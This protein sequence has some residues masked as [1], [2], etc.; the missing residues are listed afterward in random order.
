[1]GLIPVYVIFC[2]ADGP[3]EQTV[4]NIHRIKIVDAYVASLSDGNELSVYMKPQGINKIR[5]GSIAD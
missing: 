5:A 4:L 1:M 3:F 2:R